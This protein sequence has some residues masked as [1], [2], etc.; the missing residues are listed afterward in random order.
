V[1]KRLACVQAFRLTIQVEENEGITM[2]EK[3]N[4]YKL[5]SIDAWRDNDGWTWNN[6]SLLEEDIYIDPAAT[7]R[8]IL[9]SLRNSYLSDQSKGRVTIED[10]GYNLVILDRSTHEPIFALE[11]Q[12]SM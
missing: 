9:K 2:I 4:F 10:D 11:P 8:A 3:E 6:W 5:L 7:T 1:T 12:W